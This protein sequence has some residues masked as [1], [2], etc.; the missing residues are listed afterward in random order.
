MTSLN[1]GGAPTSRP[2]GGEVDPPDDGPGSAPPVSEGAVAR[3]TAPNGAGLPAS[4][5]AS[6]EGD[7]RRLPE[8]VS[9]ASP[10]PRARTS[11]PAS[12]EGDSR[13]LPEAVSPT[14]AEPRAGT[15]PLR[16][17][18]SAWTRWWSRRYVRRSVAG[19]AVVVAVALVGLV[20]IDLGPAVRARAERALGA[21]LEREVS[22]G[23]IGIW[24][25]GGRFS[26]ED[27]TIGGLNPGDR[28]FLTAG[29]ITL[30]VVW[31]ALLHGEFLADTVHMRDWRMLAESFPDGRQS[32][33]A[34]VRQTD[35]EAAA[36]AGEESIAVV[37]DPL[38][39]DP[40]EADAEAGRRF[41]T[42]L[43]YLSASE[44]EFRFE[45]HGSNWSVD[46]PDMDLT[47][48]K[49]LDYRGHAAS[50]GGVLRIGDFVPMWLDLDTDFLIDGSDVELTRI[51]L[52]TD[53]A[54]TRLEGNVDL[55]S[56]PEMSYTLESDIDLARM[57]EIFF[58][59]DDFTAAGFS[60]FRGTFHKFEGGHDLR[61][62]FTSDEAGI[63]QLRFPNMAGDLRWRHDLFE[64]RNAEASPYGGGGGVRL[65][66]GPP[67]RERA[68]AGG[69]RCPLRRHRAGAARAGPSR[70]AG[71]GRR[72][73]PPAA[74]GSSGRSAA[75]PTSPPRARSGSPLRRG[76]RL[77]GPEPDRGAAAGGG[78]AVGPAARSDDAHLRPRRAGRVPGYRRASGDW[79]TL[80]WPRRRPTSRS[81]GAPRGG[82]TPA[83]P[84]TWRA[85][86]GRRATA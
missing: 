72:A 49:V 64:V 40:A 22:I 70:C 25:L 51:G 47:I 3:R 20:T 82:R 68:R 8:A 23:R 9:P 24:L 71:C 81:R 4:V 41:V 15:S 58:A 43:Q 61:G 38:P 57:R 31:S 27:L 30:S 75:S 1:L 12:P 62:S 32:F 34:F 84:S 10:E 36:E 29:E 11:V 54:T 86:A 52:L 13:R 37:A 80:T 7:S 45:D 76:V 53:G 26:V 66:D 21:Y 33:P 42:T 69:V 18:R 78:P 19:A 39:P 65:H 63:D 16:E 73:G 60:R 77:A 17:L 44:G 83:S 79:K 50:A 67:R 35:G 46:L 59:D 56:F 2:A 85:R 74:T 28:P 48:T 5:P 14:S 55:S 6:P